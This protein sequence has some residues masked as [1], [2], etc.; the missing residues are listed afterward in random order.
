MNQEYLYAPRNHKC[1]GGGGGGSSSSSSSS[2]NVYFILN[3]HEEDN[4]LVLKYD[5][6]QK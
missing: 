5:V 6:Q 1:G 4:S 3:I 2:S